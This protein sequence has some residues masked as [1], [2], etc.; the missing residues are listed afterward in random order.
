MRQSLTL[1]M[2]FGRHYFMAI[3]TVFIVLAVLAFSFDTVE[4]LRRASKVPDAPLGLVLEMSLLKLPSLLSKLF[5]FAVLFGGMLALS[6]LTRSQELTV[7]RAAGVSVWQF[8]FPGLAIA[9]L[10]GVFVVTVY[11]PLSAAM[12]TRYEA[13]EAKA[14]RGRSSML[15]VSSG[16][17]WLREADA[18]GQIVIHALRVAQQGVRLHDAI[19][20]Y[21]EGNDHFV[22]RIDAATA[23]LEE[24]HWSLQNVVISYPDRPTERYQTL[25]VATSLTFDRIQESFASP[26]TISFWELPSFIATLE[27]AGFSAVRHRLHFYSLLALPVLLCGMFLVAASFSLRLTRRGGIGFM[28]AGGVGTG[29]LLYFSVELTQPFGLNGTLPVPLAAW[30]PTAVFFMLGTSLLFHLEDG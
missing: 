14:L 25:R 29:F 12:L 3:L 10:L 13:I 21:F 6:R 4:L 17:L 2:Y 27:A 26:S 28:L 1:S 19:L 7:S 15:A 8:L 18:T 9:F 11:N 22:K 5:P 30:A 23:F 16:G 20:F 24:G